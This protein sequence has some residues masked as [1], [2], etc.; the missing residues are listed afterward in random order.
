MKTIRRKLLVIGAALLAA[1][2]GGGGGGGA[3]TPIPTPTPPEEVLISAN[4]QDAV[5]RVTAF[6]ILDITS[7][8]DIGGVV[9]TGSKSAELAGLRAATG[10]ARSPLITTFAMRSVWSAL[11]AQESSGI[12]RTM[13]VTSST[14]ACT[15]SG[16]VTVSIDD[17]DNNGVLSP[18]DVIT[19]TFSQCRESAD[20][21]ANGT[22]TS[23]ISS[24]TQTATA[25]TLELTMTFQQMATIAGGSSST[26][27]GTSSATYVETTR[28][29]G[30]DTSITLRAGAGGMATAV[31]MPSYS[32]TFAFDE[33][34]EIRSSVFIPAPVPG[35]TT[36][37]AVSAT[38]KGSFRSAT[39]GGKIAVATVCTPTST[40]GTATVCR[41]EAL[42]R[43]PSER[44]PHDGHIRVTGRNGSALQF[45]AISATQ[46]RIDLDPNGDGTYEAT[47]D[48][49]W[50]VL[51][52]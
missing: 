51:L 28:T 22:I 15:V 50:S 52:P 47:K 18:N 20:V 21:V 7:V 29:N 42:Q 38:L 14:A 12:K 46:V 9:S 34:Y 27:N 37:S 5:A 17:R 11:Q 10:E 6:A 26:V 13:A 30:R 48:V 36:I 43:W 40:S 39:L 45:S 8:P 19:M 32:D 31:S 25:V 44:Y 35:S 24:F 23:A 16:S 41:V 1:S 49:A 33:G 4:N 2:C 3:P